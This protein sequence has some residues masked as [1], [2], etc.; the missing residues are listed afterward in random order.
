MSALIL[1][2]LL[3]SCGLGLIV[4][5][6]AKNSITKENEVVPPDFIKSDQTLIILMWGTESYDKFARKAFNKFY[7]GK[8]LFIGMDEL[9]NNDKYQDLNKYPYVFSQGPGESKMYDGSPYN[10]TFSGSRPFHI[11]DR[12]EEEFYKSKVNSGFY[13]RVMQAYAKKLNEFIEV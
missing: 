3:N 6:V 13:S 4:R 1:S 2:V 7:Q 5:G 11:F 9:I 8:K 12:R 10:Y